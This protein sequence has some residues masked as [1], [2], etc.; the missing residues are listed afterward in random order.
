MPRPLVKYIHLAVLMKIRLGSLGL[1]V[2][3]VVA[4]GVLMAVWK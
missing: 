4:D 3:L 1:V 2:M